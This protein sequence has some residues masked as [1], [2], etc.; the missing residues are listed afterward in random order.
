MNLADRI[1]EITLELVG[2]RSE[3]ATEEEVNIA[4]A[5]LEQIKKMQYF[6]KHPE[7]CGLEP[8]EEDG[9]GRFVVWALYPD[10]ENSKTA[11][12]IN[13]TDTVDT[14]DYKHLRPLATCPAELKR[15]IHELGLPEE[16]LRDLASGDWLFGRGTADMK[17]GAAIELAVMEE[18][19]ASRRSGSLLF[20]AVADEENLSAGMRQAAYLLTRLKDKYHLEYELLI[21]TETHVRLDPEKPVLYRGSIGKLMPAIY[22]RGVRAHV[23]NVYQGLNPIGIMAYII[24]KLELAKELKDSFKGEETPGVTFL[25][26]RDSKETYDVSLPE[27]AYS[28]LNVLTFSMSPQKVL[29]EV[30]RLSR[31]AFAAFLDYYYVQYRA[32]YQREPEEA[33][34]PEVY[35]FAEIFEHIKSVQGEEFKQAWNNYLQEIAREIQENKINMPDATGKLTRFLVNRLDH[36]RPVVVIALAPPYYPHV[37][38]DYIPN[39]SESVAGLDEYLRQEL[40]ALSG[41]ELDIRH[42]YT[43]ISDMSYAALADAREVMGFIEPNMPLW[44]SL[45]SIPLD[46]INNLQIPSINLGPWGKDLHMMSE[47]VYLPDLLINTPLMIQKTLRYILER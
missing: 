12:M 13:H 38:L 8:I 39:L 32:Y 17:G 10:P 3:T 37:S 35:T 44:G 2:I 45:Y 41:E 28:Y 4:H 16:V 33:W 42:F 26:A 18:H 6:R 11:V 34:L 7:H 46:L 40:A 5:M 19:I 23:G 31:E 43:G 29:E 21:D 30:I 25:Y 47:R 22:V 20:L 24:Q 1:K 27:D 9:L 15:H 14:R 36:S